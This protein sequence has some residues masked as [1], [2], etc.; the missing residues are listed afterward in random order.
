M[1]RTC[2]KRPCPQRRICRLLGRL[3]KGRDQAVISGKWYQRKRKSQ[4]KYSAT[5][6]S[7]LAPSME[8]LY[9]SRC[10]SPRQSANQRAKSE[11][12]Q[13]LP[14][15]T[16]SYPPPEPPQEDQENWTGE[17]DR[18]E[19]KARQFEQIMRP[20]KRHLSPKRR[21]DQQRA[22]S[23]SLSIPSTA[24]YQNLW[25]FKSTHRATCREDLMGLF[26]SM[27][28]RH[29]S[30]K[31]WPLDAKIFD[32]EGIKFRKH[33]S[34][35]GWTKDH[36]PIWCQEAIEPRARTNGGPKKPPPSGFYP[37]TSSCQVRSLV[38]SNTGRTYYH[39]RSTSTTRWEKPAV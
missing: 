38:D 35:R 29:G 24:K 20:L 39:N 10:A 5:K 4:T 33:I 22:R 3:K 23:R 37:R 34:N 7:G 27:W 32:G 1:C 25:S 8:R 17:G 2:P 6:T 15:R 18:A 14:S 31:H 21:Q 9:G 16:T 36:I 19:W 26:S 12:G 30:A 13:A 28:R 11:N